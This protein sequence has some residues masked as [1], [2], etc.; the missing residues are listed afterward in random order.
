[1]PYQKQNIPAFEGIALVPQADAVKDTQASNMLNLRF[2][3]LGYLVNRNGVRAFEFHTNI[4]APP[5]PTISKVSGATSIGEFILSAPVTDKIEFDPYADGVVDQVINASHSYPLAQYDRFMVYGIRCSQVEAPSKAH[6]SYV[7]VPNGPIPETTTQF[8]ID[9]NFYGAPATG[10]DCVYFMRPETPGQSI[11]TEGAAAIL[12]APARRMSWT[13]WVDSG[14]GIADD[15]NWVEHYQHMTQYAGCMVIAD[16]V[17]GDLIIHDHYDEFETGQTK[18][19]ALRL[20]QNAKAFFDVDIV[21]VDPQLGPDE[22]NG[23]GVENGMALYKFYLQ[24]KDAIVTY[25]GYTST[26]F[27]IGEELE[28]SQYFNRTCADVSTSA[29]MAYNVWGDIR[30]SQANNKMFWKNTQYVKRTFSMIKDPVQIE[31]LLDKVTQHNPALPKRYD[32][33]GILINDDAADVY[34]WDDVKLTYY[35]CTGTDTRWQYLVAKDRAWSKKIPITS[36]IVKLTTRTGIDQEIPLG[37]YAYEFVWEL[38]TGEYSTPSAPLL[39]ADKLWS[40]LPDEEVSGRISFFDQNQEYTHDKAHA[41]FVGVNQVL[42]PDTIHTYSSVA[43]MLAASAGLGYTGTDLTNVTIAEVTGPPYQ[44]Y[45]L[46]HLD[47]SHIGDWELKGSTSKT[48]SPLA[49]NPTATVYGN[50]L[51]KIKNG[52]YS[53]DHVFG[54]NTRM[55]DVSVLSTVKHNNVNVKLEGTFLTAMG[56]EVTVTESPL[57]PHFTNKVFDRKNLIVPLLQVHGQH[58]SYNS[59]FTDVSIS[60][61]GVGGYLRTAWEAT[62]APAPEPQ[63]QEVHHDYYIGKTNRID[64]LATTDLSIVRESKD[65][66]YNVVVHRDDRNNDPAATD[67]ALRIPT[68]LRYVDNETNRLLHT[69][70]DA[71]TEAIDRLLVTGIAELMLADYSDKGP[72]RIG[73]LDYSDLRAT[74]AGITWGAHGAAETS[75]PYVVPVPDISYEY[76]TNKTVGQFPIGSAIWDTQTISISGMAQYDIENVRVVLQLPGERLLAPEQATAYFPSSLLFNSP[77]VMLRI[78]KEDIPHR[79]KRLL[80]F[81]TLA[82]HDNDWEPTKFGLVENIKLHIDTISGTEYHT[83]FEYFDEKKDTELDFTTQPDEFDGIVHP[84]KSVF[85][86]SLKEKIW[87]ANIDET[88]QPYAPRGFVSYSGTINPNQLEPYPADPALTFTY[89]STWKI[90]IVDNNTVNTDKGFNNKLNGKYHE[91]FVVFRDLSGEYS[92]VKLIKDDTGDSTLVDFYSGTPNV[93]GKLTAVVFALTG[94]PYKASIDVCEVYRRS[95]EPSGPGRSDD[96]FYKIGEIKA[97]DEGIFV[98]NGLPNMES[99][100]EQYVNTI[101]YVPTSVPRVDH[102]ESTLAW[103]ENN[104]PSWFKYTSRRAFKNGDGDQITG[105]EVLYSELILFK[106]HSIHRITLKND[107]ADIGRVEEI[108]NSYGCIAPNTIITYNNSVYFLSW[109]GFMKYDNNVVT[110]ADGDFAFELDRRLEEEYLSVRNPA[111]RDASVALNP[112]YH[113]L[114]LNIPAYGGQAAYDYHQEGINGHIYVINLD[115]TMCTKFQYETGDYQRFVPG[116]DENYPTT[117][118]TNPRTMGRIYYANSLGQLHSA[119]ILPKTPNVRSLVNLESPTDRSYDMYQPGIQSQTDSQPGNWAIN[120]EIL[121]EDVHTWWRSKLWSFN[122]KSILKRV[123]EAISYFSAGTNIKMGVEFNNQ[124]Y[125][126]AAFRESQF[127]VDGE[128]TLRMPRHLPGYDRGERFAVHLSSQGDTE[129]QNLSFYWR[130]V[131]TWAR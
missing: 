102:L 26:E 115:T 10:G 1:M 61:T 64:D 27:P 99:R 69:A 52:L 84:L 3:K 77:R 15:R 22:K 45:R 123:R 85:V 59:V 126:R 25:D 113:E 79:A 35:P 53:A 28:E 75:S 110:K 31:S 78:A 50:I 34:I 122:D 88:Y 116:Q 119:E 90:L 51:K 103:S 12:E 39:W 68:V 121:S 74:T 72:L 47:G 29:V 112:L 40:C 131:N 9:N 71:S 20:Q 82:S 8:K 42:N 57:V 86:K 101:D 19:H 80:I 21:K 11:N 127:P 33:K 66:Y 16:H 13:P 6:L 58:N 100:W 44:V 120:N 107:S 70:P 38:N 36:K 46:I 125:Q 106:E 17:N 43:A 5:K 114:Y 89:D 62:I 2:E 104:E 117:S 92:E 98:D 93:S 67:S 128:L 30:Y 48:L 109:F 83:D 108:A 14:T 56:T 130:P 73:D 4:G 118:G 32:D 54:A 94:Y 105:L 60:G 87:T 63:Y 91:Y 76:N 124:E 96:Y 41:T 129:I 7:L 111:I 49:G 81:R 23:K 55:E 97:A 65:I 37:I 24:K 18:K 95:W